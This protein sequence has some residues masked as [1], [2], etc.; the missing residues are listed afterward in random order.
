MLM[1]LAGHLCSSR[2]QEVI[3]GDFDFIRTLPDMGF[4][5]IQVN[6]T[7]Q[8]AVI[9]AKDTNSLQRYADNLMRGMVEV[10]ALE[11]ILQYNT[12]TKPLVD[13]ILAAHSAGTHQAQNFSI[14]FDASMGTGKLA[15]SVTAP[16]PG[17]KCGYAG[18]LGP[19]NIEEQI[20]NIAAVTGETTT[21]VD[22]ESSLRVVVVDKI[23]E[24][25]QRDTFSVDRCFACVLVGI[26]LGLP[27]SRFTLLSI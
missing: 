1:R 13:I 7:G 19:S 18:G 2:C 25:G 24:G 6:A 22:M 9:V 10:P 8:N 3:E 16:L 26:K 17:V 12:E 14:L 21:W 23:V 20:L 27:I 11:W 5:R 15:T 4:G